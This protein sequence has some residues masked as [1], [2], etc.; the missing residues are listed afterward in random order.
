VLIPASIFFMESCEIVTDAF[1]SSSEMKSFLSA[2]IGDTDSDRLDVCLFQ[3]GDINKLFNMSD[4]LSNINAVTQS[5]NNFTNETLNGSYV[6]QNESAYVNQILEFV[7]DPI[8]IGANDYSSPSYVLEDLNLWSDYS[9]SSSEQAAHCNVSQDRFV[10]NYSQCAAYTTHFSTSGA[11]NQDF[12]NKI[13][14]NVGDLGTSTSNIAARYG[15]SFDSCTPVSGNTVGTTVKSI[16]SAEVR[17]L[18]LYQADVITTFTQI[19]NDYQ[20]YDTLNN[21]YQYNLSALSNRTM[22]GLKTS[23]NGILNLVSNN[24]TGLIAG[25]NCTFLRR[26]ADDMV[27]S[28]CVVFVP[29]FYQ[30]MILILLCGGFTFFMSIALMRNALMVKKNFDQANGG[31]GYEDPNARGAVDKY[32]IN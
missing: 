20:S 30:L 18:D 15:T 23:I 21:E 8:G 10:F 11:F 27:N 32:A 14:I 22:N 13:C 4:A 24:Q 9:L 6:I 28:L 17:Q 2:I 29:A 1:T 3:D 31:P 12:T 16:Y 19:L 26:D 25:L 7:V 5:F